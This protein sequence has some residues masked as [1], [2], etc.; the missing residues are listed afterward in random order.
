MTNKR[1]S[2]RQRLVQAALQLFAQQGVTETT[3]RQIA[4]L[5][6]VNEVTL[7]RHFGS[8]HGLLSAVLEEAEVFTQIGEILAT[9]AQRIQGFA[10]ALQAYIEAH[11]QTLEQIPEFVRSLVG[12]AGHYSPENRQ[13]IG[14]GLSQGKHYTVQ[15]LTTIMAREGVRSPLSAEQ[16]ASLIDTVLLGY[17]VTE[18]T[19][20]FHDLWPN[21]AAFIADLMQLLLLANPSE[22]PPMGQ[23]EGLPEDREPGEQDPD[24]PSAPE[25]A[26]PILDTAI[27]D[28][29]GPLVRAILQ[30]ARSMGSQ[31]Y[32]LVYVMF[33]AGLNLEEAGV[34]LRSHSLADEHQHLLQITHPLPRQ[35]S[36][37]QWIMGFRYGAYTKN[38]LLQWLKSRKDAQP[39]VFIQRTGEPMTEDHLRQL[40][41]QITV[42]ILT[43]EGQ[44]PAPDQAQQTWRVEM[45]MRG[46]SLEDLGILC[47]CDPQI[48]QPY[49]Q[50]AREKLALE[51][52]IR[53]DQPPGKAED[54]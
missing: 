35:V 28:L 46:L 14:Q 4:D 16:L 5:A 50:R 26:E 22:A 2:A 43:P 13:A 39:A 23:V 48:L 51:Q 31:A 40:W 9:Q 34:L 11:L 8:K 29:P 3:T 17:A 6:E 27:H 54:A 30:K 42:D 19:T 18:F 20:E 32:A 24:A 25:V 36:L 21:R 7:F 1:K 52:A 49:A 45:L 38:P 37:N 47:G 53:L 44:P 12:E 41:Q 15:Y 10:P 33:G